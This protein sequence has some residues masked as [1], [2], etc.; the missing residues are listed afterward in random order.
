[1]SQIQTA[2]ITSQ[3]DKWEWP[4]INSWADNGTWV[5]W[6]KSALE[7]A[8]MT[9]VPKDPI[10]SNANFW[11]WSNY[12]IGTEAIQWDFL[13]L[14]A[15]RNGTDNWWFVLMAKTEVEWWSNWVYCGTDTAAAS[16]TWGWLILNTTDISKL[17]TCTKFAQGTCGI[18]AS[19]S[20]CTYSE[21]W[22]LRY[23]LLY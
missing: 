9:S 17:T 1:L 8:W 7:T 21:E 15:N 16:W 22:Q 20:T 10:E 5:Q 3:Q 2:I 4:G 6:I 19:T 14:I 13:Y 12:D 18:D 23:I 11:L